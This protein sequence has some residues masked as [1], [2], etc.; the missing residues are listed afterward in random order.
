MGLYCHPICS[1]EIFPHTILSLNSEERLQHNKPP[2][3][4][5]ISGYVGT[6]QFYTWRACHEKYDSGNEY[7]RHQGVH[8][9]LGLKMALCRMQC[10]GNM[11]DTQNQK[12]GYVSLLNVGHSFSMVSLRSPRNDC[13]TSL[14]WLTSGK[15]VVE[16]LCTKDI[17]PNKCT[18]IN[19]LLFCYINI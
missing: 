4:V 1:Q 17:L 18:I 6:P 3:D 7:W 11:A 15:Q 9:G 10:L 2:L 13:S 5:F 14:I 16:E 12:K 8:L 19:T